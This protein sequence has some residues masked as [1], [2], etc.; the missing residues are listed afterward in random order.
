MRHSSKQSGPRPLDWPSIENAIY[1]LC[2]DPGVPNRGLIQFAALTGLRGGEQAALRWR[3][4]DL[5]SHNAAVRLVAEGRKGSTRIVPLSSFL[6]RSLLVRRAQ[7]DFHNEDDLVFDLAGKRIT[8]PQLAQKVLKPALAYVSAT[9][10]IPT[11]R[12]RWQSL[13]RFAICRW[14]DE[15]V[16]PATIQAWAGLTIPADVIATRWEAGRASEV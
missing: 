11:S 10:G 9:W 6:V 3:D 16:P 4:V 12:V 14:I 13:R 8:R 5:A 7:A 1:A 15:T 2:G